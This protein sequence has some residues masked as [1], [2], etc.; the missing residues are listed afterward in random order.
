MLPRERDSLS[1]FFSYQGPPDFVGVGP[2]TDPKLTLSLG[3]RS[4][5]IFIA[6]YD[7]VHTLSVL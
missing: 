3:A 4:E 7:L 2:Q 6:R 1:F 5:K